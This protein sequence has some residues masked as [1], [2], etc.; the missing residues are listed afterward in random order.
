[1][2]RLRDAAAGLA[3]AASLAAP[4]QAVAEGPPPCTYDD[5]PA[6]VVP[7]GDARWTV[8]DTVFALPESFAP[9]DLVAAR[10]A[11]FDDDRPVRA[12]IV[13]DL[14]A[15]REAAAAAGAWLELQSAYRSYG[16]QERVFASWVEVDGREAALATSARPGHSEHQLGTAVDLRSAGGPAPWDVEDWGATPEGAW[17]REHAWRFGFVMSYP[18]DARARSCYAY[19]PWHWRWV[20]RELAAEIHAR[21]LLPREALW[22]VQ[23]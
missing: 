4:P 19:E 20:G 3:L 16:Y 1:V 2:R 15:L 9:T 12:V 23:R 14:A 22:E 18:P 13:P 6:R 21:G 8:L 17:L 11:G 7:S 5:R 10:R